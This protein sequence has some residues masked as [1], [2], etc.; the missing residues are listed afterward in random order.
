MSEKF[1]VRFE[2]GMRTYHGAVPPSME[3]IVKDSVSGAR[4]CSLHLP[5]ATLLNI[6][7]NTI[8][9]ES[10]GEMEFWGVDKVGL[11]HQVITL[12]VPVADGYSDVVLV[13]AFAPVEEVLAPFGFKISDYDKRWNSHRISK[14]AGENV[15]QVSVTR[16]T[17]PANTVT[18]A[19]EELT[20]LLAAIGVDV[21]GSFCEH[22]G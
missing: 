8:T 22:D 11:H 2:G 5:G 1:P 19:V 13:K 6:L 9:R 4:I 12:S 21:V 18:K 15:Y 17:D 3:I 10:I 16:Y 7:A 20:P 14:V